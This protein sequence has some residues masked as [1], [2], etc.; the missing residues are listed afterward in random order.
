MNKNQGLHTPP[1]NFYNEKQR[2]KHKWK[3]K[4][5]CKYKKIMIDTLREIN[6][7]PSV[8]GYFLKGYKERALEILKLHSKN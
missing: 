2:N 4:I 7:N 5:I 6:K 1:E 3:K 8:R